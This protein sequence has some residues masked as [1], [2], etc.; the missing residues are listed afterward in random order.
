MAYDRTALKAKFFDR[1]RRRLLGEGAVLVLLKIDGSVAPF[2]ELTRVEAAWSARFSDEF[3]STTFQVAT[4]DA[5]F[6]AQVDEAAFVAVTDCD[7]ETLEGQLHAIN[8]ETTRP[9]GVD[10]YWRI[11]ATPTGKRYVPSAP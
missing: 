9:A 4:T 11:R 6:A 3:G 2:A 10:P 8:R 5:D 1:E 7:N